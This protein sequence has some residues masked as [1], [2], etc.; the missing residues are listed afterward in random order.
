MYRRL[1]IDSRT[2]TNAP[3]KGDLE[4]Y[5][6]QPIFINDD[7]IAE[8]KLV[9]ATFSLLGFSQYSVY[10]STN[11][12]SANYDMVNSSGVE[13]YIL[14]KIQNNTNASGCVYYNDVSKFK[15]RIYNTGCINRLT[16]RLHDEHGDTWNPGAN[17]W[18]CVIEIFISK[19]K[20][21]R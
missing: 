19:K 9:E 13:G 4:F 16:I 8:A 14:G 1:F 5:L 18:S 2:A 10:F 7:E 12:M 21:E 3:T 15:T 11:L 20:T 17:D 6:N